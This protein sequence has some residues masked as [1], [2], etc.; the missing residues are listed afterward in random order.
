MIPLLVCDDSNMARKQLIRALPPEWPVS[1]SQANNGEEALA[2]IRQ[3]LGPVMLLDLTM[4]VL[5]GY[6]TLAAL[7]AEGLS[8]K[9]IVVSGD[10]Q[11]E[12]VRRVR[13]LGALAFIKKPADP[14]I[15]RQTLIDLKLFDPQAT[16][17]AQ[18]QAAALSELKV[19]FRDALREVSNVAMGRAAALLAKVLGVFVQL[20]VPQ[21]NIFEVSELHMTLLDAQ[22]GE[23]FSAICQ[24]FI[25]EAIAGEA[26]LLFH[27]SEVDDMARLLGWQPEN[28]AQTSEMLLDLASIL[29]G[30]CLAGVAEQLDLRFS[31][32][33]PQLLG[34]HASLDQL[35]QVNRQ[36]WR[37]TLAVEISYSLEGHA[38]HFDLLLLFTEDSIK[39]LT[40][41]IGYLME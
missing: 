7:R 4:P 11:E 21:V 9:V 36:R 1:L 25:G 20:P 27:D 6:Q 12:A 41:K 17:A 24:G 16:P 32:G 30:A 3:G 23:R 28:E 31:Q 5:D 39:R 26:L 22:R 37:K 40:D 10:V 34:Q 8:S 33:H 29:I 14:E 38:I 13:E 19:S 35:I 15:L 2:L 18:A